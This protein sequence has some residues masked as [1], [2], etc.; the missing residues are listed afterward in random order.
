M[1]FYIGQTGTEYYDMRKDRRSDFVQTRRASHFQPHIKPDDSVLDFGCGT[2]SVL[3]QIKCGKRIGIEVNPP[4]VEEAKA[5]GIQIFNETSAVEN[6]SIDIVISNHALEHTL[7]PA[8]QISAIT[9]VLKTGGRAILVVPAENPSSA[10][11]CR[12]KKHDPDQHIYS[13]TPLSFGNLI[14]QCGLEVESS[15]RRPIGYSKY[16]EPLANIH[17]GLFQCARRCVAFML[18]RYEIVCIARK[19]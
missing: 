14:M 12:W 13:W 15:I 17:E 9:D 6:N 3:A 4:S 16:I 2:G 5:N 18:G 19:G 10:S 11:F 7:N 8:E 1:S